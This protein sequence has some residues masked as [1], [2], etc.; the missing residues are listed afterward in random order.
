TGTFKAFRK[1]ND[2]QIGRLSP[3]FHGNTAATRIDADCHTAR[4]RLARFPYQFRVAH[5]NCSQ[6][7]AREPLFEPCFDLVERANA[8]TELHRVFRRLKDRL[9][10]S[11]IDTGS[12]EGTVEV[13][14]MQPLKPL[15]FK[16]TRL[17]GRVRIVDSGFAH[18][19]KFETNTL[20]VLE[21]NRWKEDHGRH[22]KKFA[23]RR[24]PSVWLFSGWN[25][26]PARLS[27]TT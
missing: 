9:D 27:R 23:M 15:V 26:V 22:F 16:R 13:N 4:K 21:V 10:G 18:F 17:C 19:A 24:R 5:C 8:P 6:N 20:A 1:F 7:D 25:W 3:T 11:A 12:G 14:H 2:G